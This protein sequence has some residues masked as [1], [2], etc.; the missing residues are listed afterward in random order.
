MRRM[1]LSELREALAKRFPLRS[2]CAC[3]EIVRS[4]RHRGRRITGLHGHVH[5]AT[6]PARLSAEAWWLGDMTTQQIKGFLWRVIQA[7]AL[8][9]QTVDATLRLQAGAILDEMGGPNPNWLPKDL[10]G[11]PWYRDGDGRWRVSFV[12]RV[13]PAWAAM[14]ERR[15][16]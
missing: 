3:V 16:A 7:L 5:R 2:S 14:K 4:M 15:T 8:D 13:G 9:E 10:G 1:T 11:H 12:S 6:C